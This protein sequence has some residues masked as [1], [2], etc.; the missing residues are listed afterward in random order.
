MLSGF[1][2]YSRW[3]PLILALGTARDLLTRIFFLNVNSPLESFI[4]IDSEIN[5]SQES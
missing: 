2:L 3:L 1:E 4:E 5:K